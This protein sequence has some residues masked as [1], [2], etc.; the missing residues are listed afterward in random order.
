MRPPEFCIARGYVVGQI[1]PL[2]LKEF[3]LAGRARGENSDQMFEALLSGVGR[4]LSRNGYGHM[5]LKRNALLFGFVGDGEILL[6]G[7]ELIYLDE[8]G[9]VLLRLVDDLSSLL[10]AAHR[11][12]SRPE[13]FRPV[14][15]RAAYRHARTKPLPGF[16][17]LPPFLMPGRAPHDAYPGHAV[18]DE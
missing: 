4:F 13:R 2:S 1:G 14:D 9:A 15:N 16:N 6:A 11:D 8:I 12:R 3:R 10:F 17:L 5:T 7:Q 18:G